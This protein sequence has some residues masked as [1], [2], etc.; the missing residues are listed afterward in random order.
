MKVEAL[1]KLASEMVGDNGRTNVFFVT[2]EGNVVMITMLFEA[3]YTLWS[4]L[5]NA[6][7][8]CTLEDRKTSVIAEAGLRPQFNPKTD[9]FDGPIDWEVRDDSRH[10]GFRS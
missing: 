4:N 2:Y 8:D 9:N 10:F 6:H 7:K 1:N 5:K 3:A